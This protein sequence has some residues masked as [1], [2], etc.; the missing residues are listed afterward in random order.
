MIYFKYAILVFITFL[1]K[2]FSQLNIMYSDGNKPSVIISSSKTSPSQ[3]YKIPISI[4][5]SENVTGF[6]SSD[7][8]LTE[9]YYKYQSGVKKLLAQNDGQINSFSGSGKSY[10]MEIEVINENINS[11]EEVLLNVSI[12]DSAAKNLTDNYNTASNQFNI[13]Y[14]KKINPYSLVFD[15]SNDYVKVPDSSQLDLIKNFTIEMWVKILSNDSGTL[16]HKENTQQSGSPLWRLYVDSDGKHK[17]QLK[18]KSGNSHTLSSGVSQNGDWQHLA[19][20]RD[21]QKIYFYVNGVET[22]NATNPAGDLVTD[23]PTWLGVNGQVIPL[24][25][26]IKTNIDEVRIWSEARTADQIKS[27][28]WNNINPSNESELIGYWQFNSG[29]G[30][31]ALDQTSNSIDAEIDGPGWSSTVPLKPPQDRKSVV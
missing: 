30:S 17:F 21:S 7:I 6:S 12:P 25:D 14:S 26:W 10:T 3:D 1:S 24:N 19:I 27:N 13:I 5:F 31:K 15:G 20:A 9:T 18:T 23:A 11:G 16:I 22:A 4:E 8:S 29:F 2:S 28:Y